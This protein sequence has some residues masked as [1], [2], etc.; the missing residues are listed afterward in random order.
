MVEWCRCCAQVY[1]WDG[2]PSSWLTNLDKTEW[3]N[4]IKLL[5]HCT[6]LLPVGHMG[7]TRSD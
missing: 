3:L 7:W 4:H 5:L 1:D 6:V 2:Q